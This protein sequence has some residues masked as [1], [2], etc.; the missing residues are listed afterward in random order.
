MRL[1]AK[2]LCV[3]VVAALFAAQIT[4]ASVQTV[5]TVTV[6]SADEKEAFRR[7][8]PPDK[9]RFVELV[10]RGR[11]DWLA[12]ACQTGIQCDVVVIS[13]HY[14]G[15]KEFFSEHVEAQ[16][17]LPVAEL[18]R[19]SC[20]D[21]C[22]ALFSQVKE[23]YLFGCNTLN[24]V[25]QTSSSAEVVR[26]LERSGLARPDAEL[27]AR[28]LNAGHGASSRD[29]MRM[30]FKDVPA[31]YGFSAV[32]PL[33]PVAAATLSRY[34]QAAG[35]R[36]VGSGRVNARMLGQFAAN[37]LVVAQGMTDA[38][39]H[40]DVRRDVCQFVDDRIS[41]AQRLAFIHRLLQGQMAEVRIFLDRIEEYAATL[42]NGDQEVPGVAEALR[43]IAHDGAAR[44]RYLDFARDADQPAVRARMLELARTLGWLSLPQLRAEQ[45][46]M[47]DEMLARS[48][49]DV[50]DLDLACTLNAQHDLDGLESPARDVALVHAAIRGCL[51]SAEGRAR[52]VE[53]LF[54]PRDAEVRIAQVYLVHRP[55][56][57][58]GEL[59][60]LTAGVARMIGSDAQVR[61]LQALGAHRLSD[62]ESLQTLT[63]LFP[64]AES[65]SVQTAIAGVLIR[66]DY[67]SIAR[68]ELVRTLREHRRKSLNGEDLIDALIRRLQLP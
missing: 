23:V 4:E 68:P 52:T 12:Q 40:A 44:E 30:V 39:P 3:Y 61:A 9:Y 60:K 41:D 26:S 50:A 49:T 35:T 36:E 42:T 27:L 5:C 13:G 57:D 28:S 58:V 55:I 18:E 19:A 48:T 14:D 8:L 1:P 2:S 34:F 10:E 56:A 53:A 62:S 67:D 33:G 54:S 66:A 25:A 21:S 51:G 65:L 22:P 38:D 32:A 45:V 59:R 43:G 7:Y 24:P 17:F 29:R 64:V 46:L 11:R 37:S 63:T 20:S 31:I 16:E 15:G 6:N 47:I